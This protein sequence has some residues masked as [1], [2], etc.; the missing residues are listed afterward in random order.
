MCTVPMQV[1][2]EE[3]KAAAARRSYGAPRS[4][5]SLSGEEKV[6]ILQVSSSVLP[7][8]NGLVSHFKGLSHKIRV[9]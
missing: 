2:E 1:E 5:S 9:G 6:N 8:Q 3:V 4:N 7:P